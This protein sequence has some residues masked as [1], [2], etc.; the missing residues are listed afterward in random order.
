[1]AVMLLVHDRALWHA[2]DHWLLGLGDE[3]F[4]A[5]LPLLRRTFAAYPESVRHQLHERLRRTGREPSPAA[6][7]ATFDAARA[8]AVLPVLGR[9]PVSYTHLDVY[10]RQ[11][12]NCAAV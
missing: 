5:V 8:A 10:K 11:S 2:I 6:R 1:M 9:L 4:V 3:R 12:A 7:P